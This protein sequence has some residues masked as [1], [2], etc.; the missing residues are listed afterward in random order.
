MATSNDSNANG[1]LADK[2]VVR[3]IKN[4]ALGLLTIT[5][6]ILVTYMT[7]W[8][9]KNLSY[10]FFYEDLVRETVREMVHHTNLI[11]E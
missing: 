8:I 10:T 6:F 11:G 5:A 2:A 3:T 4:F 1:R 9:S 7:Y